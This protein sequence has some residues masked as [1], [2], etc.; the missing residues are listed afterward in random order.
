M[1]KLFLSATAIATVMSASAF[2]ADL[3]SIK[4]APVSPTPL[5]TGFYAGMNS[6][7]AFGITGGASNYG[8]A[9]PNTFRGFNSNVSQNSAAS[10]ALASSY[11][12]RGI[13]QGGFIGG[14]QV[15]Y[16]YQYG[17]KIV[18]GFEA[19]MQGAGIRGTGNA[20][21]YGPFTNSNKSANGFINNNIVQAGIDWLGTARGRIGYLVTPTFQ[22]YGTGGLAYGGAFLNT[23]ANSAYGGNSTSYPAGA[24]STGYYL[25]G[26]DTSYASKSQL[27]VGYTAGAG[28]E[29]MLMPNWSIKAE[30]LYYNLG[31]Q[32][33]SNY[34]YSYGSGYNND[35]LPTFSAGSTTQ[36][37]YDG[38][39]GRAGVNYH[40][41]WNAPAEGSTAFAAGLPSL[42]S[43]VSSTSAPSWTG[44]Y[45]GLN[46]G[47]AFGVTSGAYNYGWAN[48]QAV[49]AISDEYYN[50]AF[51]PFALASSAPGRGIN[52]GGFVGGGQVGYNYQYGEKIVFGFEADMQGA[53]IRGTGNANGV[54]PWTQPVNGLSNVYINNNIIQAGI[55]WLGTARVRVGYLITP[56]FQIYGTGGIAYGIAFMNTF[57]NS[58]INWGGAAVNSTFPDIYG[59]LTSYASKSQLNV[60]Y[61]AGG[62]GEWM[63]SNNWSVKAEAIYYNLG[64]QSVENTYY[65]AAPA[66]LLAGSTTRARY[67][68]V[69]GR[70]GIN[71]H[72]D[73][74]R[75]APVVAKF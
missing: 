44:L 13:Y 20:N 21:G 25:Y 66:T 61:S 47:Y 42:R 27:L 6:G 3:P 60:G 28:A 1:K 49:S 59:L 70:A 54:G 30:A 55:D 43:P 35:L 5:W 40:F 9:N 39:I 64:T 24:I 4:S 71:Y 11:P 16:N 15:G 56:A 58:S 48:P 2:A 74:G 7:Y 46:A 14:G 23:R 69:I 32:N 34:L 38:V 19:D 45:A 33:V 65:N 53:G 8:W 41:N 18:F 68:G 31:T 50:D 52:Q 72:F 22:V 29:W 36:A 73:F 67:D 62:G 10:F 63:L 12:G 17:Q 26:S 37:R 75:A 51:A 57:A